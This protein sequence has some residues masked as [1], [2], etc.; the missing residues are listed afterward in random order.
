MAHKLCPGET[1]DV[2]LAKLRRLIVLFGVMSEKGLSYAFIAG[3]PESAQELLW[4]SSQVDDLDILE[5]LAWAWAI[6]KK[7]PMIV[8]QAA[9]VQP[10]QS[11]MKETNTPTT[12]YKCDG[13]ITW[14]ETASFGIN[15]YRK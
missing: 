15:S 12:C 10:L 4:A 13:L 11:Q 8:E 3:M 14:P 5:V 1:V 9:V 2:Y 7:S 6:L